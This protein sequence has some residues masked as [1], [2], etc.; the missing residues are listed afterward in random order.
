MEMDRTEG[1]IKAL[2][3][4]EKEITNKEEKEEIGKLKESLGS[5]YGSVFN[6]EGIGIDF[7]LIAKIFRSNNPFFYD[8]NKIWWLWNKNRFCYEMVD[9]TDIMIL[10]DR[11]MKWS[12]TTEGSIKNRIL[13]GLKR[14]GREFQPKESEK[15][16]IQFKDKIVDIDNNNIYNSNSDYFITNSI[17]WSLGSSTNTPTIDR[18][19]REW[20]G[21]KYVITLKE[22]L[23]Y[24]TLNYIPIH[25]IF[26]FIGK[27]SNGKGT[28]LKLIEKLLGSNI[29]STTIDNLSNGRF[30]TAKLFRKNVVFIS[31]IDKGI[32]KKTSIL[33]QL[34]GDD[35][36]PMEIKNKNPFDSRN[37][38]KPII[39]TNILPESLD[40][41]DGFF[42]RWLIIDFPNQFNEN[43]DI[44]KEIS[45]LE[46]ENFCKN[47]PTLLKE[48]IR[49]GKFSNEGD[50]SDRRDKYEIHSNPIEKFIKEYYK[51]SP[52]DFESFSTFFNNFRNYLIAEGFRV[53][54]NVE[55]SKSL[56]IRGF[57][58]DKKTYTRKGEHFNEVVIYGLKCWEGIK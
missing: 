18:I 52:N 34:S 19:F 10:I 6:S 22:I 9:E 25:R 28:F 36:M 43:K 47:I 37:Y 14:E 39:A 58:T 26:C 17:P 49:R 32:F 3:I 2:E 4:I 29:T 51:T 16:W 33:K 44:L 57:K 41:S 11:G 21:E 56:N 35:L 55:V 54:S 27:G 46:I 53:Q 40:K 42:R 50:I 45:D 38:A 48:L 7:R 1:K 20:V 8:K 13:E 31:E 5:N 24:T 15:T 12:A 30:E 23:A